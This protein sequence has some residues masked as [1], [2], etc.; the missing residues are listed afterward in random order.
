MAGQILT[1]IDLIHLVLKTTGVTRVGQTPDYEDT[2]DCFAILNSMLGQLNRERFLV[3][4]LVDNAFISNGNILHR[5][6]RS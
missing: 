1:P 3:Y 5:G 6:S 4:H 2:N